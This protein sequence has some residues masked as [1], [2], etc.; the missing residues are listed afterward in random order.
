MNEVKKRTILEKE[1]LLLEK[2]KKA[3]KDLEQLRK[4]R[5]VECGYLVVSSGLDKFDNS[6]LEKSFKQLA[7]EL[8]NEHQSKT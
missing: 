4:K 8:E 2:I 1:Q 3:K 6:I 5:V 7:K